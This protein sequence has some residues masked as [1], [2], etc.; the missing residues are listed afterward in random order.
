MNEF[1]KIIIGGNMTRLPFET[2]KLNEKLIL[3]NRLVMA[4]MTTWSGNSDGTLSNEELSYYAYRSRGVGLVITATTYVEPTGKGFSGQ[5]YGGD[6]TMNSS[7]KQL[8]DTIHSG[9]AKAILQI[10]HAG[11]KSNP[12][13]MPEGVS[14]SAS[15]VPGKREENNVPRAMTEDE[16]QHTIKSFKEATIRAH[17]TGFD[18]I[19]IHGAN[20]YLL[21]QYFSPHS[22][23]RTD[24]WGG[25]LNN[26]VKFPLAVIDACMEAKSHIDNPNFIIGYRFS[27]EENSEPG[28]TLEDTDYLVDTLCETDLDYLHISLGHYEESSMRNPEVKDS[29]LKRVLDRIKGRKPF[30]GVGSV[31]SIN[32]AHKMLSYGVDLVAIGRQLLIDGK[33][34]DKWEE[35]NE[36]FKGYNPE[37]Q[38]N[39]KIPKTLNEIIMSQKGW[40]P[41]D[42]S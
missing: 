12:A 20:T 1:K 17:Q 25:T 35:N 42:K 14:L 33:S 37:R 30:I 34:I 7:L 10:F 40:V 24:E 26:R 27:P 23:R 19:E 18:G 21:Q 16:I 41:M 5:F 15:N 39:E 3:K 4:P 29:T 36:T 11:R 13:D 8:A 32:D 22:N 9:G 38:L 6:D 31:Y 2:Y 28:I